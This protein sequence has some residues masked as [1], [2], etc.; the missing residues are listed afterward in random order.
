MGAHDHYPTLPP[1]R[2]YRVLWG[3]VALGREGKLSQ[4]VWWKSGIY[5]GRERNPGVLD[6]LHPSG[7][8]FPHPSNGIVI[9]PQRATLRIK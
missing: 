2:T 5:T 8:Q 4:C 7:P 3:Q 1:G 6:W 9:T